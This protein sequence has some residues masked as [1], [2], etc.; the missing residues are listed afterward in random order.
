MH[1]LVMSDVDDLP[2]TRERLPTTMP[3]IAGIGAIQIRIYYDDHG[4]PH[5]HA[6]GPDFDCKVA[7]GDV[8]VISGNGHLR[9][10][11]LTA[12]QAWGHQHQEALYLSWRFAGEASHY[13]RLRADNAISD[14]RCRRA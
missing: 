3:P 9:G 10:R 4:V 11:D 12:I 6:I 1:A 8:L 5:F 13:G 2:V 7:I 14:Q